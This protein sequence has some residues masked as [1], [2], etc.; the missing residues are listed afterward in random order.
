MA[1]T[2]SIGSG[3]EIDAVVGIAL[4]VGEGPTGR[5]LA[6]SV[7]ENPLNCEENTRLSNQKFTIINI[8]LILY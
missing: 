3:G 8:I 1:A 2:L 7:L 5:Q 4:G 6:T